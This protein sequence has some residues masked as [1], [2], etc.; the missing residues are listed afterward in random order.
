MISRALSN[1][2][3]L[4]T[5][6][7]SD[8]VNCLECIGFVQMGMFGVFFISN[9]KNERFFNS[10]NKWKY[11]E[12]LDATD[13]SS[14]KSHSAPAFSRGAASCPAATCETASSGAASPDS[15]VRGLKMRRNRLAIFGLSFL[16]LRDFSF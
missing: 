6:T 7:L 5:N 16:N 8:Y 9:A 13:L 4:T 14:R 10:E 1:R 2:W 3:L 12:Q 15:G 11:S